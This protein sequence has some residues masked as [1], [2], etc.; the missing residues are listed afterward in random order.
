MGRAQDWQKLKSP[1][2]TS[3]ER[4]SKQT[5]HVI[6]ANTG[7]N[8]F[9][10]YLF[11]FEI[12][13][14]TYTCI[15]DQDPDQVEPSK[16]FFLNSRILLINLSFLS[17][18]GVVFLNCFFLSVFQCFSKHVHRPLLGSSRDL[19]SS[20][21]SIVRKECVTS[22]RDVRANVSVT[23]PGKILVRPCK[24]LWLTWS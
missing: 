23:R 12:Y 24:R 21:K 5:Y 15:L 8:S 6:L 3:L 19:S 11:S 2:M 9:L 10:P 1:K 20:Y 22:Y 7:K 13:L 18:I 14:N 16:L 17:N 4:N